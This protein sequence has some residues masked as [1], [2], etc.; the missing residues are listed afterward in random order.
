MLY[1]AKHESEAIFKKCLNI[2]NIHYVHLLNKDV[3]FIDIVHIAC[4]YN[5]DDGDDCA[6]K[7]LDCRYHIDVQAKGKWYDSN[8]NEQITLFHFDVEDV[9]DE[10]I[11]TGNYSLPMN[12]VEFFEKVTDAYYLAFRCNNGKER[13]NRYIVVNVKELCANKSSFKDNGDYFLVPSQTLNTFVDKFE[14]ESNF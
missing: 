1:R 8:N 12:K 10:N 3:E 5:V 6:S 13:L 2:D 9:E 11:T 7:K 4:I 14:V